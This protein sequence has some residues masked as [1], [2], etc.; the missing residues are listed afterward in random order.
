MF[1]NYQQNVVKSNN[2]KDGKSGGGNGGGSGGVVRGSGGGSR[3]ADVAGKLAQIFGWRH[4]YDI[5][6]LHQVNNVDVNKNNNQIVWQHSNNLK[7]KQSYRIA[8]NVAT[9]QKLSQS[10]PD[11]KVSYS[12]LLL[13]CFFNN[14]EF[15]CSLQNLK[16]NLF[17]EKLVLLTI[18]FHKNY[19]PK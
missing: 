3:C 2:E 1:D 13:S 12:S 16:K 18:N 9:S 10:V 5:Q 11:L 14:D 8:D 4:K 19:S 7:L 6:R 17:S 15:Y